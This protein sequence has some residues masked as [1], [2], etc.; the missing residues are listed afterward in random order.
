MLLVWG[1]FPYFTAKMRGEFLA[2]L[3]EQ[4]FHGYFFGF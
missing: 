2:F 3:N 4:L 1:T